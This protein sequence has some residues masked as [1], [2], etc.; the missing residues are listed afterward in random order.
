LPASGMTPYWPLL[1]WRKFSNSNCT[2]L[3]LPHLE[4]PPQPVF[5]RPCLAESSYHIMNAPMSASQQTRSQ[6]TIHTQVI[7]KV[8]LL[9][10]VVTPRSLCPLPPRVPTRSQIL[11]PRNLSQDDFCGIDTSNMSIALGDNHWSR[12]HQS[13][14]VIHPITGKEM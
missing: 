9:P 13:N 5:Q 2:R 6:T 11:F 4:M 8:P 10:R 12:Q 7:P 3:P 14:A 1:N